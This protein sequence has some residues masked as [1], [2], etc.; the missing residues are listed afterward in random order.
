MSLAVRSHLPGPWPSQNL[1]CMMTNPRMQNVADIFIGKN[2]FVAVLQAPPYPNPNRLL[3]DHLP[4]D[5]RGTWRSGGRYD[6]WRTSV[7]APQPSYHCLTLTL[8]LTLPFLSVS[9]P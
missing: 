6:M 3:L 2:G 7:L 1:C 9:P 4:E 5:D 8:A